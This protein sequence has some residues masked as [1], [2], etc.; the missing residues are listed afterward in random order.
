MECFGI[1]DFDNNSWLITLS[2]I[3]ISGL[4]CISMVPPGQPRIQ[5]YP[6]ILDRNRTVQGN[7]KEKRDKEITK[8]PFSCKYDEFVLSGLTDKPITPQKI[9]TVWR[10]P[11]LGP[12][13]LPDDLPTVNRQMSAAWFW[14]CTQISLSLTI[15]LSTTGHHRS[16][17]NKLPCGKT[18]VIYLELS[19]K[20]KSKRFQVLA[21]I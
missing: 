16:G 9:S 20:V 11:C 1:T 7:F 12:N 18:V 15:E 2:A 4:H 17:D 14:V 19:C 13:T 3:I 6:N 10:T 5:D 8:F 21:A